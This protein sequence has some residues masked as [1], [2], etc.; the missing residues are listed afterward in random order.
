MLT[1]DIPTIL[2]VGIDTI[3]NEMLIQ[4]NQNNQNDT[5]GYVIYTFDS[6][7]ILFELDTIWG[8][9][10]ISYAYNVNLNGG[11]Y[12]YSVAAF[13][14]CSTNTVPVTFQTSAKAS[15][16]TSICLLYTSPS[17]RDQRGS[18]MPSSA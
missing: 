10:N 14:S 4:W 3:T 13:D 9:S 11:P 5:Y 15:I 1:P 18:R 12:S 8:N 2:S 7:G 6:N 16:N 17:P